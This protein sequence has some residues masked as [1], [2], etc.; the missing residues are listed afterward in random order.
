MT[1]PLPPFF[2]GGVFGVLPVE[3][4][5]ESLYRRIFTWDFLFSCIELGLCLLVGGVTVFD[6]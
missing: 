1:P 6:G 2:M 4:V 3:G 5:V